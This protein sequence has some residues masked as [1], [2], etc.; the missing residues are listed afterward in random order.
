MRV[1]AARRNC[2]RLADR[3][4][5]RV[6][7]INFLVLV[8]SIDTGRSQSEEAGRNFRPGVPVVA[9]Q[10]PFADRRFATLC[11]NQVSEKAD[12]VKLTLTAAPNV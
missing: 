5:A 2:R 6:R 7:E 9:A 3:A 10:R 1:N 4:V 8:D 12:P 11:G